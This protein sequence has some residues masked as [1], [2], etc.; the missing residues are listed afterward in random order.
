VQELATWLNY[1]NLRHHAEGPDG[2][3]ALAKLLLLLAVDERAH[4]SFFAACVKLYLKYDR[5]AVL[6]QMR[7]VMNQFA[8]PAI[9]DLVEGRARVEAIKNLGIF[10]Q[11]LYYS[12]VY[13]PVLQDLGV[14]RNEM[15]SREKR[16]VS[17]G[18]K[19]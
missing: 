10:D 18:L 9:D 7:R 11:N 19:T 3:P 4:Y 15:R 13:L 17:W 5:P 1:R 8:M 16:A 14:S 12:D 6:E 2:D